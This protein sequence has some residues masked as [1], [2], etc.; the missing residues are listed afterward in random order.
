VALRCGH[1][2]DVQAMPPPPRARLPHSAW[3]ITRATR[4]DA[5]HSPEVMHTLEDAPFYARSLVRTHVLGEPV[6][7]VHESLSLDRFGARWV[8]ALLPFRM[9][10]NATR[11]RPG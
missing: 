3:R 11:K 1:D 4:C 6:L 9:P 10:R 8:Q 5:G 7:A 2:G